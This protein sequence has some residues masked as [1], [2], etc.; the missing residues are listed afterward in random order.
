M[1]TLPVETGNTG[2]RVEAASVSVGRATIVR[3]V[4]FDAAAGEMLAIIG[5]SG[6]GKT[7][8]MKAMSGE[9]GYAGHILL[10]G[11]E[12]GALQPERL[13]RLRGVLPQSSQIAF[14]LTVAEVIGLGMLDRSQGREA[15]AGRIGEA[16]SMVDLPGFEGRI[17]PEL[18][19]GEQQRVQLARVLCQV[20][21]PLPEDGCPR[22][23]FL[24][25]PVSSLDIKHQYQIM[26]LAADYAARGGGVVAVMH[27]LNLTGAFADRV[28]VLKEGRRLAFGRRDEIF[29]AELL[30]DAYD[31][32]LAL[33]EREEGRGKL[34]VPA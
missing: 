26:A 24:D 27:D 14:P 7:T 11:E 13:A 25:E 20:W 19:G 8:L 1:D 4:S 9:I 3:E 15:R 34:V 32:P 5:P 6:S 21:E 29:R 33:T 28:L 16:L 30:S 23:L 22:W 17:Y 10:G 18:S 2:L 31:F 12:I